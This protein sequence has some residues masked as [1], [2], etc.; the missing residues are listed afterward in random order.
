MKKYY[1]GYLDY[2]NKDKN[3]IINFQNKKLITVHRIHSSSTTLNSHIVK[4]KRISSESNINSSRNKDMNGFIYRKTKF[5]KPKSVYLIKN[6][7]LDINNEIIID[8][9]INNLRNE[10]IPIF[11]IPSNNNYETNNFNYINKRELKTKKTFDRKYQLY[12]MNNDIRNNN[13]NKNEFNNFKE[14]LLNK[15]NKKFKKNK[16]CFYF[17]IKN[18]NNNINNINTI[19][20]INEINTNTFNTENYP[21]KIKLMNDLSSTALSFNEYNFNLNNNYEN[22]TINNNCITH[23]INDYS[24]ES[25][26]YKYKKPIITPSDYYSFDD[27]MKEKEK[28]NSNNLN[29][30]FFEDIPLETFG[31]SV[32]YNNNINI[33][34]EENNYVNINKNNNKYIIK[35]KREN[36]FL[37][38][39]LFKTTEKI[40]LLENKIGNLI[41]E[42][43]LDKNNKKTKSFTYRKKNI[44]YG[45]CPIST[46][47]FQKLTQKDNFSK[48]NNIEISLISKEKI[49]P[50]MYRIIKNKKK[51]E[52][53][54]I[55]KKDINNSEHYIESSPNS[56]I[57][58]KILLK[59]NKNKA[60]QE[61]QNLIKNIII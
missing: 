14:S 31:S 41:E 47:Y 51:G 30:N 53:N 59:K 34:K 15:N 33:K 37:K 36:E 35:L 29:N 1:S 25:K 10:N 49:K 48:E 46:S 45:K 7:K 40:S 26:S 22:K 38:Q 39:E 28:Q 11:F 32:N 24:F 27:K 50:N 56:F 13:F 55:I 20:S 54:N 2:R 58:T 44:L 4:S 5:V 17:N 43:K 60:Y 61:F 23:Y 16:T 12:Y 3:K 42:K 52:K 21:I 8:N 57:K 18:K 9:N 19:N 6:K